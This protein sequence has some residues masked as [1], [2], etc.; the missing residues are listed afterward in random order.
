MSGECIV[1][2]SNSQVS[3]ALREPALRVA[4]AKCLSAVICFDL[5]KFL[6]PSSLCLHSAVLIHPTLHTFQDAHLSR[7]A[8]SVVSFVPLSLPTELCP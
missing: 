5:I 7:Q 1:G 2:L 6:P 4:P 3:Y 8:L